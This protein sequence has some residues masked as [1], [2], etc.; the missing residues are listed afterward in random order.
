VPLSHF[1]LCARDHAHGCLFD[2]A[3]D[4]YE[5]YNLA[6]SMPGLFAEMLARVDELQKGVYSP[7]RGK[8]DARAC[9][10][11]KAKYGGYWGP[12]IDTPE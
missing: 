2:V 6:E 4:P 8:E 12:F 1:K 3:S 5:R 9:T 11:A 7:V 10:A